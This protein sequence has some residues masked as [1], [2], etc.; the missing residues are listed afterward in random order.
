MYIVLVNKTRLGVGRD[1]LA[2][3]IPPH[4][5]WLKGKI[6]EGFVLQ[7]GKWGDIGG[8]W[9]LRAE[10]MEE[11]AEAVREDPLLGSGLVE[12]EM[13]EYFPMVDIG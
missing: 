11:A 8:V 13:A 12:Y 1:R 10:S 3:F 9:I 7:A 5:E 6:R 2:E 4:I